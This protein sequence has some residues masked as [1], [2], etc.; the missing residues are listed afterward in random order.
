MNTGN[1]KGW[2]LKMLV[3]VLNVTFNCW[4]MEEL[5]HQNRNH[6]FKCWNWELE[7]SKNNDS[8]QKVLTMC[9]IPFQCRKM[10]SD[11]MHKEGETL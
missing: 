7:A 10:E 1:S 3:Q 6:A 8:E 2:K 11:Y 4:N 9:G 5:T